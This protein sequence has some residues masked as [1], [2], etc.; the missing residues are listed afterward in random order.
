[1]IPDRPPHFPP[2]T[3]TTTTKFGWNAH[4]PQPLRLIQLVSGRSVAESANGNQMVDMAHDFCQTS[5]LG[6]GTLFS[7]PGKKNKRKTYSGLDGD[8]VI[9]FRGARVE[10]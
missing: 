3:T 8:E 1:M 7:L 4:A 9:R 10:Q 5:T 2:R 6:D